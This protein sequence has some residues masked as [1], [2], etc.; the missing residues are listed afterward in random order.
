MKPVIILI[1]GPS[2]GGKSTVC[3]ALEK[4]LKNFIFLDIAKHKEDY[5]LDPDRKKKAYA[6]FFPKLKK[7]MGE[8]KNILIQEFF[9]KDLEKK[10]DLSNYKVISFFL[11]SSLEETKL[12]NSNRKKVLSDTYLEKSY[13]Y[14]GVSEY[15]DLIIDTEKN[16]VEEIVKII[17]S[18]LLD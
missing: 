11:K 15:R 5:A 4:N 2:A 16:S 9:L 3:N 18:K 1:K 6:K 10:V 13:G 7:A 12:R 8:G 14:L 17:I